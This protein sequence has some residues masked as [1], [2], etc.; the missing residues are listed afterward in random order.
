M[1]EKTAQERLVKAEAK[2]EKLNNTLSKYL[3]RLQKTYE[4]YSKKTELHKILPFDLFVNFNTAKYYNWKDEMDAEFSLKK[5]FGKEYVVVYIHNIPATKHLIN[6]ERNAEVDLLMRET[7]ELADSIV[8]KRMEIEDTKRTIVNYKEALNKHDQGKRMVN[9]LFEQVP[10]LKEFIEK[11]GEIEYAFLIKHN[12]AIKEAWERYYKADREC[13][14]QWNTGH[15]DD[16]RE[17]IKE[18]KKLKP[19]VSPKTER[20]IRE[21]VESWKRNEGLLMAERIQT[22]FGEVKNVDLYIGADGNVNGMIYGTKMSARIETI[23]A[24][25]YNIQCLHTR[26]LVHEK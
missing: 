3:I 11:T 9:E 2:L 7:N 14:E 5:E 24:G 25:G 10:Q 1:K 6:S 16:Y 18:V 22:E 12:E 21:D 17:K 26:L 8:R 23:F 13:C 4:K 20:E 19:K 15:I